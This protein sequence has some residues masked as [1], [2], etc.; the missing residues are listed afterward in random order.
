MA[1]G[2]TT[3]AAAALDIVCVRNIVS[4]MNPASTVFGLSKAFLIPSASQSAVPDS[5][6]ATPNAVMPPIT[7]N[8]RQSITS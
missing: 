1:T 3:N 5:R 4:K 7:I 2:K 8:T 6:M